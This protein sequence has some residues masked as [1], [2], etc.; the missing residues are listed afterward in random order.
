MG[1]LF[2]L[3]PSIKG[4]AQQAITDLISQ[5]GK[6]CTLIWPPRATPCPDCLPDLIGKKSSNRWRT[7]GPV[8]F[9]DGSIC[10]MCQGKGQLFEEKTKTIKMLCAWSPKDFFL[11]V[12]F[13]IQVPDNQIQTKGFIADMPDVLQ[14]R[15]MRVESAVQPYIHYEFDLKTEPIDPGNIVQGKFWIA[16]WE[17]RPS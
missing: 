12:P 7:G 13:N 9:P 1:H 4:I 14:A 8:W 3:T 16:R 10:P 17:R 15:R 6:D 2:T 11:K 5:L